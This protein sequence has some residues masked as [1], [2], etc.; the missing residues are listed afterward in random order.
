VITKRKGGKMFQLIY[1]MVK[2]VLNDE[3]IEQIV[4]V[5]L[6]IPVKYLI[7]TGNQ[8]H[9]DKSRYEQE[10]GRHFEGWPDGKGHV[11]RTSPE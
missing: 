5:Y 11:A 4:E 10:T 1:E 2:S 7:F 8:I 9:V 6:G 3:E